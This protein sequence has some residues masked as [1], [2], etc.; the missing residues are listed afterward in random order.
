MAHNRTKRL[1]LLTLSMILYLGMIPARAM[2]LEGEPHGWE[3]STFVQFVRSV[4]TGEDRVTGVIAAGLFEFP[5]VQQGE[6][7][8]YVS[9]AEDTLTQ[10]GMAAQFGNIGLLAHNYLAGESF[11]NLTVGQRV[12]IIRGTGQMETYVVTRILKYQALTPNSPYSEFRE[13]GGT[14]TITATDMFNLAYK[15]E[16]HLTFQTC[17][18]Q[19][20]KSSWGRLF[21][22]AEPLDS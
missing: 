21:V 14:T 6:S 4:K 17:I 20:G 16:H 10:F 15:G 7:A 12:H 2:A 5:V 18:E 9:T 11:F 1:L 19:D 22:I 13:V 8:G 3:R